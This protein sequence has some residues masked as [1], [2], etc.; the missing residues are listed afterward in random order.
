[1]DVDA[2]FVMYL[3]FCDY[4]FKLPNKVSQH[5][6]LIYYFGVAIYESN[7]IVLQ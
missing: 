6:L 1:M 5:E 7:Q 2:S 3:W 4:S